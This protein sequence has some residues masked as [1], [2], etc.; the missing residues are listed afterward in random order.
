M[1]SQNGDAATMVVDETSNVED[2]VLRRLTHRT[3]VLMF[4]RLDSKLCMA[5]VLSYLLAW[6]DIDRF[7]RCLN[8]HG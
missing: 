8:K 1:G 7:F 6:E 4:P 5:T 2:K 3:S